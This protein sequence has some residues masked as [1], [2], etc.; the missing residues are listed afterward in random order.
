MDMPDVP[1]RVANWLVQ[2]VAVSRFE[3]SR[4]FYTVQGESTA[5]FSTHQVTKSLLK[6]SDQV[7]RGNSRP[8]KNLHFISSPSSIIVSLSPPTPSRRA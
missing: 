6:F 1:L 4:R 7:S 2:L 5:M 3:D 8:I